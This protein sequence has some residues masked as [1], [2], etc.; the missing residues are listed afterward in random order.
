MSLIEWKNGKSVSIYEIDAQ[1]KKL[2]DLINQLNYA[3]K[4][5]EGNLVLTHIIKQFVLFAQLLF[6]TEEKYFDLYNYSK[7]IE[8]KA[9]HQHF[10][11]EIKNIKM[12]FDN[13]NID[14]PERVL[15]FLKEWWKNHVLV[16]DVKYVELF[17]QKGMN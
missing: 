6:W 2:F 15:H 4:K 9:E 1:H 5:D 3:L 11:T 14:F 7:A 10:I 12:D 17:K 8:H 13:G 16:E